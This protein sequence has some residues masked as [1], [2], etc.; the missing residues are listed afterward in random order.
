MHLALRLI[1]RRRCLNFINVRAAYVDKIQEHRQKICSQIQIQRGSGSTLGCMHSRSLFGTY[2]C[3]DEV[4]DRRLRRK[5]KSVILKINT[6]EDSGSTEACTLGISYAP[7]FA[8]DFP[9]EMSE[10]YQRT[11]RVR[12]KNSGTSDKKSACKFR[13]NEIP[14]AHLIL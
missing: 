7:G 6:P 12:L 5:E 8:A 11:H 9:P 13:Y 10:F 4:L 3:V 2:F 1:F 14:R